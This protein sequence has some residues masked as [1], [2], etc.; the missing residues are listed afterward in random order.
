MEYVK[1]VNI[2]FLKKKKFVYEHFNGLMF[3]H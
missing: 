1:I 3:F 2:N